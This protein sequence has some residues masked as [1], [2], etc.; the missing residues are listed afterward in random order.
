MRAVQNST[1]NEERLRVILAG[2]SALILTVGIARFAYTPMLPVMR[3]EA[4]L[5]A[6]AGGWLATIN[7]AGYML[8]VLIASAISDLRSKFVLY[9]WGLIAAVATTVATGY[10]DNVYLWAVLRFASGLSSIAGILLASGL[11][12]NW[13]LRTGQKPELGLHFIGLGLGVALSGLCAAAMAGRLAWDGQ[14]IALGAL[15]MLFF[16]PAWFWMPAPAPSD[17]PHAAGASANAGRAWMAILQGI[18]FCAGFG[19]VVS[20]TFVVAIVERFPSL[21]GWGNWIWVLVG[22]AAV[23]SSYLWDRIARAIGEIPALMLA[24][25]LQTV[26]ILLTALSNTAAANITAAILFGGTFAGIVSLTLALVGRFLPHNPAK[27][28]ARLTISYGVAQI[29]APAMAGLMARASGDYR[30]AL[31][32][33]GAVMIAGIGL[34]ALL[35][36]L[37]CGMPASAAAVCKQ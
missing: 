35:K 5:S 33:A 37:P 23:P 22:L 24:F 8:G 30:G 25:A 10:T 14:W 4:G 6:L 29:I 32:V 18:Y 34:L 20:A 15:G 31:F 27:A 26:S 3:S 2:I 1:I 13:L 12:L 21:S 28:M 9:R 11:I 7:Y 17:G 16:I 19:Y 36:R